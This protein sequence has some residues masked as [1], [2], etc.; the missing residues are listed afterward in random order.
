MSK[1]TKRDTGEL[2]RDSCNGAEIM[3]HTTFVLA[4]ATADWMQKIHGGEWR[5][6]IEHDN[7]LIVIAQRR[8]S[9]K[10]IEP[11]SLREVV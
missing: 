4:N 3:K 2:L 11:S 8:K 1:V 9:D 10:P 7:G 6:Q 5:V